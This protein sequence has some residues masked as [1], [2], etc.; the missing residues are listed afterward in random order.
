MRS[1]ARR[2]LVQVKEGTG[3]LLSMTYALDASEMD[4]DGLCVHVSG[5]EHV[6]ASIWQQCQTAH[7]ACT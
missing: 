6:E 2:L 1:C 7:Q 4:G 5:L 3:L